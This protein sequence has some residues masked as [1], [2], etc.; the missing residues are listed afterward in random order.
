M[1]PSY[2]EANFSE[3]VN[4]PTEVLGRLAATRALLLHRRDAEDLV[5]TTAERVEQDRIV[6]SVASHMLSVLANN[7][8][9]LTMLSHDVLPEAFPWVRFLPEDEMTRF[10]DE[11]IATLRA[12]T[13]LNNTAAVARLLIEWKS[14]AEVYSDPELL[15]ILTKDH[16]KDHDE[17]AE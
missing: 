17:A 3:L 5:V 2:A 16:G 15:S 14:T 12:S 9:G 7:Q 11:F 8:E 13:S 1:S 6:L 10:A 4:K